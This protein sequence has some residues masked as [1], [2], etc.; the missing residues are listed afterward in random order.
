MTFLLSYLLLLLLLLSVSDFANPS[1]VTV[2]IYMTIVSYLFGT[3]ILKNSSFR[4]AFFSEV[5]PTTFL[6]YFY[7]LVYEHADQFILTVCYMM[8]ILRAAL[9]NLNKFSSYFDHIQ[10]TI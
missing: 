1:G 9:L 10:I 7:G 3:T 4:R 5:F 8:Y 2:I 6:F